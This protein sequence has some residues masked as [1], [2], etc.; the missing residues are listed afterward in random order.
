MM[1]LEYKKM[2]ERFKSLIRLVS[3]VTDSYTSALFLWDD[4]RKRLILKYHYTLSKNIIDSASIF[5]GEGLIGWVAENRSPINVSNFSYDTKMLLYYFSYED[6][7]SFFA[8]PIFLEDEL[9]GVLAIDSKS[10]WA[11][12]PKT[13]K[14]LTEFAK[15]FS[16]LIEE[17]HIKII[18]ETKMIDIDLLRDISSKILS[19]YDIDSLFSN[20]CKISIIPYDG[21]VFALN[22]DKGI[23][24]KKA[25]GYDSKIENLLISNKSLAGWIIKNR[26]VL[27]I[28]SVNN[29]RTII[30]SQSESGL[31]IKSFLGLPLIHM[32]D[33]L[34]ILIF[35]SKN[36]G[37]FKDY[38]INISSLI[39]LELA[40]CL[41]SIY[42]RKKLKESTSMDLLTGLPNKT[43]I[44]ISINNYIKKG[45]QFSVLAVMP[46]KYE[47]I[48]NSFGY[49]VGAD[50][51][52]QM[53]DILIKNLR[54]GDIICRYYNEIFIILLK[55]IGFNEA[56][57][58][59]N[60]IKNI[61]D[62][63]LFLSY[64]KELIYKVKVGISVFPK[65]G[66]SVGNLIDK[67][68]KD[69]KNK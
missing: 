48:I 25:Y 20:L 57:S 7:K 8:V 64:N 52:K 67:S 46:N 61:F 22:E 13:Q 51:L 17:L 59:S 65:D 63:K 32:E 43:E 4:R 23:Y 9:E 14:I 21:V 30:F 38:H 50:I 66:S 26:K 69:L 40:S 42:M 31:D 15:E 33:F 45:E 44:D 58:F 68:I 55:G 53:A 10:Q 24:I 27:N 5:P 35:T 2:D 39:G 28:P 37:I 47:N 11:F 12:T 54:E 56:N 60:K 36:N 18:K 49:T 29:E 41:S 34:G 3:I 6:I 16:K 62:E 19:S 1:V